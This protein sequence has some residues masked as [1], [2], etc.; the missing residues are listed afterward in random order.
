MSDQTY[1]SDPVGRE[2]EDV[3]NVVYQADLR[4]GA[5]DRFEAYPLPN[6]AVRHEENQPKQVYEPEPRRERDKVHPMLREWLAKRSRDERE[7]IIVVLAD[8]TGLPRFPEPAT[9]EPRD[10][11][12]NRG[13][14]ERA[15]ELVR[16]TEAQRAPGYERLQANL[17]DYEANLV[18]RFWI[19]N[20]VV[21]D[22][23]LKSVERLAG[24]DDVISIEPRFSG[25]EP[26]QDEVDDARARLDSDPYFDAGLTGGWIG[27]LDTGVRFSH[28]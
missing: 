2:D 3:F 11:D 26:P 9:D 20:G 4:E 24:R 15:Q 10:S 5:A 21:A 19:I 6:D 16:Q 18:E 28:T 13:L 23:P 14:T 7:Q 12:R 25:E 1:A 17:A 27:L 22:M 8:P